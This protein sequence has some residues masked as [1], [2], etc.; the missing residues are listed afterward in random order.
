MEKK[1]L[2]LKFLGSVLLN[3][4][5]RYKVDKKTLIDGLQAQFND[6]VNENNPCV[7]L[8][9]NNIVEVYSDTVI[10]TIIPR[11]G[12]YLE[13]EVVT[14]L[15][16]VDFLQKNGF[17]EHIPSLYSFRMVGEKAQIQ[18]TNCGEN[19]SFLFKSC[20]Y[21]TKFQNALMY[22]HMY[23]IAGQLL[24]LV[25]ILHQT[26][27]RHLDIKPDNFVVSKDL[28]VKLI[29]F[30]LSTLVSQSSDLTVTIGYRDPCI[31]G[32]SMYDT[33]AVDLFALGVTLI[34]WFFM[35]RRLTYDT[36]TSDMKVDR[37]AYLRCSL[38]PVLCDLLHKKKAVRL[39]TIDKLLDI[40][41]GTTT[42]TSK[43]KKFQ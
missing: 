38:M 3:D 34:E 41:P 8:K 22:K 20:N 43:R 23:K 11:K 35:S 37:N 24:H 40:L 25:L 42:R 17:F 5:G 28:K 1:D 18:S 30:G 36:I 4:F 31:D 10:K 12:I 29:D 14:E 33:E 27:L 16:A 26:G 6:F 21:R 13:P 39:Q 7:K 15:A 19:L 9:T 32:K 2:I